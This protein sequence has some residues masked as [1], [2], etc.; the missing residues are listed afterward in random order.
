M[1]SRT[2]APQAQPTVTGA[3]SALSE[4]MPCTGELPKPTVIYIAA[5]DG[6]Y[7]GAV[8]AIDFY[9]AA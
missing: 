2:T 5:A 1:P 3:A 4:D 6:L 9:E 8:L 7:V